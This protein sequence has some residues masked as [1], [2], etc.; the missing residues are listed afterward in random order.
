MAATDGLLITGVYGTGKSSVCEEIAELLD[1][2]GVAYAAID[3]D[4][5]AW[6][7]VLGLGPRRR[8]PRGARQHWAA[9]VRNYLDAGV[10]RFV[11]AGGIRSRTEL[12]DLR[13][14]LPF[15]LRVVRLTLPLAEIQRRLVGA[16]TIGR[17]RDARTAARWLAD[18]IGSD[19]KT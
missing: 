9:V 7:D 13:A 8:L 3:L 12:D 14:V 19:S 15:S 10:Q 1:A 18:G 6:F 11:L 17:Q 4:W 2:A 5:L 16:I